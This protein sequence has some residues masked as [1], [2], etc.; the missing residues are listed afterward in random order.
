MIITHIL[1]FPRI[2]A[3]RE[4]KRALEAYWAGRQTADELAQAGREL[5]AAH[6]HR[7]A[8]AGLQFVWVGGFAWYDHIL[9]W[10]TLLGAV[11]PRFGQPDDQRAARGTLLHTARRPA[12]L[13]RTAAACVEIT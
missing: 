1:G 8:A 4:L 5:R 3:Q 9:E 2:G 6:W 10:T 11:P 13:G 7:Q 12:P